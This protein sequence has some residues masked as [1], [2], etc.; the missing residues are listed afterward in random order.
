M[1]RDEEF[2]DESKILEDIEEL[3]N[4]FT[5]DYSRVLPL[6][7]TIQN[8][9]GYIPLKSFSMI[10]EYFSISHNKVYGIATFYNQFKFNPPGK[11]QIKVCLGTACHVKGANII[12]ENFERKLNIHEGETTKDRKYS[13]ERVACVGCCSLAPVVVVNENVEGYFTPSKVEGLIESHKI[14]E[15]IESRKSEVKK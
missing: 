12:L 8:K 2:F 7:Q 5:K 10:G 4:N 3:L 15:E 9:F 6:L 1:E 13:L 14:Q 11:F